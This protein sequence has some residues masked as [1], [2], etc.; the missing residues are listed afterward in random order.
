MYEVSDTLDKN[1]SR[2]IIL[3]KIK[4]GYQTERIVNDFIEEN[5][6]DVNK[7]MGLLNLDN[8]KIL[9]NLISL[10]ECELELIKKLKDLERKK[11]ESLKN[12]PSK[13][14]PKKDIKLEISL[15]LKTWSNKF[16]IIALI[17]ISL[18]SLTKQAWA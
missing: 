1:W 14:I 5:K 7:L 8:Y 12:K 16:V 9:D 11:I 18:I 6:N 2:E 15:F 4:K 3:S 10:S 13:F 17:T